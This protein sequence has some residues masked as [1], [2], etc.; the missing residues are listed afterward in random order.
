MYCFFYYLLPACFYNILIMNTCILRSSQKGPCVAPGPFVIDL[1]VVVSLRMFL[2]TVRKYIKTD[3]TYHTYYRLCE[4]YRDEFGFP[5]QRMVL[6]LGRMMEIPDVDQKLAFIDRLNELIN[7]RP[8]LFSP[9]TDGAVE[10]LAQQVYHEL[11]VKRRIDRPLKQDNDFDLINLKTLKNKN[12]REIGAESISYQAVEQLNLRGFLQARGW[13]ENQIRLALTHII[14]RAVYPASEYKTVSWIQENSAICGLTGYAM[15]DITKDR[16]YDI[17]KKLY[18]EKEKLEDHLSRCTNEL[19]GL[20]DKIILYDLTNT[21]FEGRMA[22]SILAKHGRSKEKRNDAKLIVL[23]LIVNQHG[24]LKYSDIFEGNTTDHETL[25]MVINKLNKKGRYQGK[26]KPIIVMDA[27]ISKEENI[28]YL[29]H[30]GYDYMC[31]TRSR[32]LKYSADTTQSPV[33]IKDKSKQVI[34]LQ[35]IKVE[36]DTDHYLWV[37]SHMKA[38]KGHSMNDLFTSRFEQGLNAVERGI[39]KKGGTKRLEKVWERI[40]R[41]K[42]KYPSAHNRYN[43][44]V[45]HNKH[46]IATGMSYRKKTGSLP[47]K[48]AGVYFLRTSLDS[49][50]ER[51]MWSIYNTIRDIEASFRILKSDL[52]LRP[53]YHKT[54]EASMAHLHLGLMAYWIVSTIRYQLKLKGITHDWREIVRIMNT[55]KRVTTTMVNSRDK[56]IQISQCSEPTEKAQQIFKALGYREK[57]LPRKKSVW[58]PGEHL[59]KEK[60]FNQLVADG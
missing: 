54:D 47:D 12:I 32:L 24:F 17:A 25:E 56:T 50:D 28:A 41:L 59:K 21:Y 37:K 51:S 43:I 36:N 48:K 5:R 58:H 29:R 6:G 46:G 42:E 11:K 15:E 27:G 33:Q 45:T 4:S 9:C 31:V 30:H 7:H 52:D 23:A 20:D 60:P 19:F 18:R 39:S 49:A 57:I 40:G 38:V 2:K 14:S 10:Q 8:G 55:Q 35:K 53:I 3:K 13:D 44:D 26:Q 34:E 16:L 22:N 1:Q